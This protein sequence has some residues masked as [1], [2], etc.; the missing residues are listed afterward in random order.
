MCRFGGIE[1]L[2]GFIK[3]NVSLLQT[4]VATPVTPDSRNSVSLLRRTTR[5]PA[6]IEKGKVVPNNKLANM[7]TSERHM[8]K[9]SAMAKNHTTSKADSAIYSKQPDKAGTI[10]LK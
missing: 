6:V 1:Q 7:G 8:E 4:P 9:L 10:F 2:P 3:P 5:L